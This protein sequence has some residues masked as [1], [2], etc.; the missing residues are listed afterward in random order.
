M[1]APKYSEASSLDWLRGQV[2]SGNITM[3]DIR[4]DYMRV[5]KTVKSRQARVA[6]TEFA[7]LPNLEILQGSYSAQSKLTD[8][9]ILYAYRDVVRAYQAETST[10][11]GL[12]NRRDRFISSMTERYPGLQL[13]KASY[14]DFMIFLDVVK[15]GLDE[16]VISPIWL[17]V[18]QDWIDPAVKSGANVQDAFNQ[19]W[20]ENISKQG[21]DAYKAS[22]QRSGK[23]KK[24][25]K[26][27]T[28][29]KG[30]T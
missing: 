13:D 29:K 18:W 22:E 25:A 19:W 16:D 24:P 28:K 1:A 27:K 12:K 15:S 8:S 11:T 6:S 10:I 30:K 3:S 14:V 5:R 2:N 21:W 7:R 9:Q 23:K 17:E 26:K 4:A 20:L